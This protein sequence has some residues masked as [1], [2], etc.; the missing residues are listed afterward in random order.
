MFV[1]SVHDLL[2]LDKFKHLTEF[3]IVDKQYDKVVIEEAKTVGLD[4]EAGYTYEAALH[5][6]MSSKTPV[7]GFRLIGEVRTDREFRLSPMYTPEMQ[8][9]STTR[10]DVS[11]TRELASLS[12]TTFNATKYL[13]DDIP[14]DS[15]EPD[16]TLHTNKIKELNDKLLKIRGYPFNEWQKLKSF[17]EWQK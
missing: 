7:M 13:D 16:E 2:Q 8:M 15:L 11:L 4:V 17:K 1:L 3:E 12:G 10:T 5:R 14:P 9:L 6:P